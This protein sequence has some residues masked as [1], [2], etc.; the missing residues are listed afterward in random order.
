MFTLSTNGSH[1]SNI[2]GEKRVKLSSELKLKDIQ[3]LWKICLTNKNA[4]FTYTI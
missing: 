3:Y 2:M 1:M 4:L